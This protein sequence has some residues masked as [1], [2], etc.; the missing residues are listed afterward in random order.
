MKKGS[1]S[2][3]YLAVFLALV[4]AFLNIF[5]ILPPFFKTPPGT[6]YLAIGHYGY[7]YLA[8]LS[9][10]KQGLAGSWLA[11]NQ[12]NSEKMAGWLVVTWPFLLAGQIGRLF[13]FSAPL[14]YWLFVFLLTTVILLAAYFLVSLA[15][16]E[17]KF[18]VFPV[19]LTFIFAAPFF[20]IKSLKPFSPEIYRLTWYSEA[21]F[22]NRLSV[23]PHHL[24]AIFLTLALFL[25]CFSFWEHFFQK[26]SSSPKIW[27]KFFPIV[28]LFVLIMTLW[29][30]R[31]VYL[32]PA[33]VFSFGWGFFTYRLKDKQ[34]LLTGLK[35]VLLLTLVLIFTGLYFKNNISHVYLPEVASWEKAQ[36][37]FPSLGRFFLAT[38]PVFIFGWLGLIFLILKKVKLPLVLVFG[39]LASFL[40]YL[41]FFTPVSL[42]FSNHNSRFIFSEAYLFLSL[43]LFF[44]LEKILPKKIRLFWLLVVLSAIFSFPS[45]FQVLRVR[46]KSLESVSPIH[47]FLDKEILAGFQFLDHLPGEKIVL[48]PPSSDFGAVLPAFAKAKVF[49]GYWPATTNYQQKLSQA[50]DFYNGK[51]SGFQQK[52]FL[53][54]NG[55]NY[56]ILTAYDFYENSLFLS[57]ETDFSPIFSNTKIKIFTPGR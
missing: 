44:A 57:S 19:F 8:C 20:K 7:D 2:K 13:S 24:T 42:I 49:L 53:T 38:G 23:I 21:T 51:M 41:L 14:V 5:H 36:M 11:V 33:F 52:E 6:S 45:F 25:A 35:M 9:F 15:C 28:L 50:Q 39:L 55:I 40:S 4:F 48:T 37:E 29:P 16:G 46:I 30:L 22:L 1:D 43:A 56:I 12:F 3:E 10:I 18:L 32:F 26:K 47:L 17:K 54:K 27:L 34:K 31:I